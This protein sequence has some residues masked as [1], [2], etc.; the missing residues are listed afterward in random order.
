METTTKVKPRVIPLFSDVKYVSAKDCVKMF[1]FC[2]RSWFRFRDEG[3][4]PPCIYIGASARWSQ[5]D[6]EL[7]VRWGCPNQ[8]EFL[9]RRDAD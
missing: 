6:L 2:R 9:R 7:W 8:K 1:G 3:K 4:L 5:R